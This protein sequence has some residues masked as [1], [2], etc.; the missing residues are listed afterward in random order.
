MYHISKDK[1]S[2]QS[3]SLIIEALLQLLNH[4]SLRDITI[5]EL[6]EN[7]RVGRVTFYRHFD[8]IDDV[9]RKHCDD[10]FEQLKQ[11]LLDF[12]KHQSSQ[13][14]FL[15]PLLQFWY[16]DSIILEILIKYNKQELIREAFMQM[17]QTL[18]KKS[19]HSAYLSD[20]MDS[21]QLVVQS[22]VAL[23]VLSKW[24]ENGKNIAPDA[25]TH[26]ILRAM[27]EPVEI[28]FEN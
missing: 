13:Q 21:Y 12:Y 17:I 22:S 2:N 19:V 18:K 11:Y 16:H 20:D 8:S 26:S 3:V 7:A 1:R 5:K 25:L 23:A 28:N 10:R 6:C 27:K 24:I 9:L 15:K 4:Q 14:P